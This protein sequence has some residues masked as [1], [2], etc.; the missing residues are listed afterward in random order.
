MFQQEIDSE[1]LEEIMKEYEIEYES[2]DQVWAELVK[3]EWIL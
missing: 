2:V 3:A 1:M